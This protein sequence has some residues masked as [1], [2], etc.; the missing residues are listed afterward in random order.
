MQLSETR[1]PTFDPNIT[2]SYRLVFRAT[3]EPNPGVG[4]GYVVLESL[5]KGS[6]IQKTFNLGD[7]V[8]NNQAAYLAL[9]KGLEALC[10]LLETRY[11]SCEVFDL[12][13]VCCYRIVTDALNNGKWQNQ[14]NI[15]AGYPE[16]VRY[17]ARF[18]SY[19]AE[20][21]PRDKVLEYLK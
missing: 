7:K 20:W 15:A 19:R 18:N 9:C 1:Y 13:I 2:P 8:T 4:R 14:D 16:I 11:D 10:N 21:Q 17:L 5:V 12:E 3:A 6:R